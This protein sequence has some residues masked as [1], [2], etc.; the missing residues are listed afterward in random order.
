[1][2]AQNVVTITTKD[3]RVLTSRR[4]VGISVVAF[5][6]II[7]VG[8]PLVLELGGRKSGGVPADYLPRILDAFLFVFVIAAGAL[9]TAIAA[10]S[11]VGEKVE[12]SLEPLLATPA[13]DGEI[14]LGKVLAS[15]VPTLGAIWIG[16]AVFMTL[17]DRLARHTLGRLYFPNPTSLLILLVVCPLAALLVVEFDVVV[18][19]RVSDV[20]AAQQI[21]GLA[22]LPFGAVYVTAEIGLI[23]LDLPTLGVLCAV[24]AAVDAGMFLLSRAA[25]RREE[26]LTRW[27]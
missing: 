26:I 24:L 12:R 9:P 11:L 27:K 5:P 18:S 23:K 8:L 6:T 15:I 20:R 17:T 25:F 2:N 22:V 14:L 7:A 3:L 16:A 21:G 13:T 4:S 19:G 1:M 10:Y